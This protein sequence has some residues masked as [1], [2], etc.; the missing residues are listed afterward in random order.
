MISFDRD[1]WL[2]A[3]EEIAIALGKEGDPVEICLIGSAA[4][5]FGGMD[6]RTS[7]DLNV[8]QPANDYD[9]AELKAAVETAGLAFNPTSAI[10]P[11]MP[12][13]QIVEP[14][15]VQI[16]SF[17]PVKLLRIGRLRLTRPPIENIIAAKLTRC[18][19][20]DL[21]DIRYLISQYQPDFE[22]I[23]KIIALFPNP[24]SGNATANLVYLEIF[25]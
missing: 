5:L 4:C 6:G 10:E 15:I 21:A 1:R 18:A 2:R 8:W 14:G 25:Q 7:R 12:Y 9:M 11:D 23:L 3:L 24:A 20:K 22:L 17:T 19:E 16:G 13:L